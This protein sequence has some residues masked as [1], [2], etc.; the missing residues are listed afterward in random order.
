MIC[1]ACWWVNVYGVGSGQHWLPGLGGTTP[2]NSISPLFLTAST[3][4]GVKIGLLSSPTRGIAIKV[5]FG[6]RSLLA[7]G[8]GPDS[9]GSKK[10]Q[11]RPHVADKS[12]I[13]PEGAA[14]CPKAAEHP[15][16]APVNSISL[17][18]RF[19]IFL[20]PGTPHS[21]TAVLRS[22]ASHWL[23]CYTYYPCTP[24]GRKCPLMARLG[25]HA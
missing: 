12:G 18:Y 17:L 3:A 14:V 21:S 22:G 5:P 25:S 16:S 8:P 4:C 11:L 13:D 7:I 6:L 23:E 1:T 20:P 24:K 19:M 10:N 9:G 15:K 2:L